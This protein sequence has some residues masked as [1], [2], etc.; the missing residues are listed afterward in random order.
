MS[1]NSFLR[2]HQDDWIGTNLGL[3][4]VKA[5]KAAQWM[6]KGLLTLSLVL[7]FLIMRCCNR[8]KREEIKFTSTSADDVKKSQ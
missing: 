6:Y 8:K 2:K 5:T 1:V 3:K 4:S 7:I